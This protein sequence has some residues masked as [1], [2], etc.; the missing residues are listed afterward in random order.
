MPECG[1]C[2]RDIEFYP[3]RATGKLMPIDAMATPKGSLIKVDV[4]GVIML[5]VDPTAKD[6]DGVA[7][8]PDDNPYRG[9]RFTSHFAT[10]TAAAFYRRKGKV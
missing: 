2:K 1:K 6:D 5:E 9:E 7:L 10:C 4:D 3:H 8:G